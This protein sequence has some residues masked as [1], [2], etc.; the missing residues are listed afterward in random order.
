MRKHTNI[1]KHLF[2]PLSP[3]PSLARYLSN[4]HVIPRSDSLRRI[5]TPPGTNGR[6]ES[7]VRNV[8]NPGFLSYG[9]A[10]GDFLGHG[11]LRQPPVPRLLDIRR[12]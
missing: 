7:V 10:H 5:A 9:L 2:P 11:H 4:R 12:E 3:L 8:V 6:E 1:H